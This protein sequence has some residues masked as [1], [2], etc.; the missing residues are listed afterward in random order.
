[1]TVAIFCDC[2]A[3]FVSDL[4]GNPKDRFS[5]VAVHLICVLFQ[6][7]SGELGSDSLPMYMRIVTRGAVAEIRSDVS[8]LELF[9]VGLF[10]LR[11]FLGSV[12][13][14]TLCA[15]ICYNRTL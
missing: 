1:M 10:F 8:S 12:I 9:L 5:S 13:C 14:C 7:Q 11:S 4:V 6:F 2:T 15:F 3:W